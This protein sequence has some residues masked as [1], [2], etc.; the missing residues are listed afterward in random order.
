YIPFF[1][2]GFEMPLCVED[3]VIIYKDKN[4]DFVIL[5]MADIQLND[6]LDIGKREYTEQTIKRLIEEV[7]PDL[8]TMTG[9]QVWGYTSKSESIK[10]LI[11][12]I[13]SYKIPWAPVMGN[14]DSDGESNYNW[15]AEKY[16][17]SKY[18]LFRK[19]LSSAKGVG[20]Y[21][22]N[23][24]EGNKTIHSMIMM[25]SGT[26]VKYPELDTYGYDF[27][28][29]ESQKWYEW[30]LQGLKKLS[31]NDKIE[32]SLFFHI[33]LPEFTTAYD[34]WTT[35]GKDPLIGFGENREKKNGTPLVNSNFFE[36]IK[37][38]A[39]T[40]N[41]FVGHDHINSASIIY[42]DVRLT[43]CLKTGDRCYSNYDMNGGTVIKMNSNGEL[44][45]QH[46]Y[47]KI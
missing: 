27:I 19:G 47:I 31:N 34:E 11:D 8:I 6:E 17:E 28:G 40:K 20:N 41:V 23:I 21:V 9:D 43:Y 26:T 3:T 24:K 38:L 18:C 30:V 5:N 46:H 15:C 4:K 32:T 12:I 25:D 22:I 37:K 35:N 14:H 2:S 39:S 44:T 33:P 29:S 10:F 13:D 1:L 7:K 16:E 36:L 42:Q 45:V